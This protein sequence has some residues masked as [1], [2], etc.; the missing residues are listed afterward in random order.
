M[1]MYLY[2]ISEF[3]LKFFCRGGF[4]WRSCIFGISGFPTNRELMADRSWLVVDDVLVFLGPRRRSITGPVNLRCPT[5]PEGST[6]FPSFDQLPATVSS[7]LP[8]SGDFSFQLT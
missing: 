7:R 6:G 5:A 1:Y 3:S 4:F 8:R 2:Q